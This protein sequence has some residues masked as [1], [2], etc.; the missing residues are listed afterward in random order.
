MY[1]WIECPQLHCVEVW[2]TH[3]CHQAKFLKKLG[4]MT[5]ASKNSAWRCIE[6]NK[7]NKGSSKQGKHIIAWSGERIC[8]EETGIMEMHLTSG[9]TQTKP[10]KHW[11]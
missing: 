7:A 8:I 4:L 11:M 3:A 9:Y 10:H 6:I 2:T 1:V 5:Q